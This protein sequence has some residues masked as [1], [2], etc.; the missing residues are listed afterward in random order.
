MGM[1]A[2]SDRMRFE[3]ATDCHVHL[4]PPRLLRAIREAIT[5]A[6]GWEFDHPV[7]PA[8]VESALTE[9]GV[10]RYFALPYAHAP[11]VAAEL[12]DWVLDW[13]AGSDRCVPFATV[14]PEDDV[15]A[16]V[17]AAFDRGARGLKF[18]CPV[19]ECGPDD[20]RLDPAFELAAAGDHPILFHAGTAPMYEDSPYVGVEHFR[21]F[22]ESYPDVRACSA[23]MGAFET[24]AF[25]DVLRDYETAFLD[26]SFSMSAGAPAELAFDPAS[27]PDDVF[28]EFAGRIMYGSD[29]PNVPYP[30][31]AER[32]GLLGRDLSEAATDALFRGAA[33]AFLGD[34][35]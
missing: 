14:H 29:F 16:V 23:H 8:A 33:D 21:G 2:Q 13:A 9:A 19:Q 1:P 30:Y 18:Q 28:E 12:N 17:E 22:F 11:D 24:E 5:E 4:L 34:G 20:P 15:A 26:T 6:A 32:A 35:E 10:D 25:L 3:P 31:D 27:I 7:E